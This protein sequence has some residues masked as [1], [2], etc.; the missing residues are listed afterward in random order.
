MKNI[1]E[2]KE[3]IMPEIELLA[4]ECGKIMLEA[5][6][7]DK[8]SM[9]SSK[10]GL[11]NYVTVFDKK[12][13]TIAKNRLK[14]ILPEAFFMGEENNEQDDISHGYAFIVDP[15]DG[16]SNFIKGMRR[17]C[18]S[19]GLTLDASPVAGVIYDPYGN[20]LYSAV[21]GYGAFMNGEKMHVNNDKTID[22]IVAVGTAP[23]N[24][25][26][27]NSVI[28]QISKYLGKCLDIRR[29]GSAALDL[30]DIAAG[31]TCLYFEPIVNPWDYCAGA[32]IVTEAGGKVSTFEGDPLEFTHTTSI[33]ASNGIAE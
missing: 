15:I 3:K 9:I 30:C 14:E 28:D 8:G 4:K 32:V 2:I 31:R 23:Y 1:I 19:I 6:I 25:E 11:N 24:V 10:E 18:I 13:Q 12:I 33:K 22:G 16:T 26:L 27:K 17:S 29:L 7:T 20:F 21:K 5:K